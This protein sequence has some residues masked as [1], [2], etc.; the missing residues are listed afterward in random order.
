MTERR[1]SVAQLAD[2]WGCSRQHV[3]N[4]VARREIDALRVGNLVRFRPQDVEA[5]E[6]AQCRARV[7]TSQPIPLPPASKP[8]RARS[9]T[10]SNG[11]KTAPHA[12]FLAGQA[13]LRRRVA[14]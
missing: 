10:T 4:L 12:G 9:A 1:L 11:G 5:Y 8:E 14:S 13:S 7:P 2:L 6:E 3:Y